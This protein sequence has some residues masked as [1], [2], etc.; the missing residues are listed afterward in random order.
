M[1]TPNDPNLPIPS[2]DSLLTE[3]LADRAESSVTSVAPPPSHIGPWRLIEPLG[4]GGMGTVYLAGR[5][6]QELVWQAAIKIIRAGVGGGAVI[7]RFRAERQILASLDH[8]NIA[9]MYDAGTL[10]DGR[11]YLVL[12][13][14]R[15]V[16]IDRYCR[17]HGLSMDRRVEIFQK[18]CSAVRHAHQHLVIHRDLK[19]SNILVGSDGEPKLL[20]FGIAKLLDPD[21]FPLPIDDTQTGVRPMTPRYA[22]PEQIRGLPVGTSSDVFSLGVLLYELITGSL[23]FSYSS[24]SAV[25][26]DRVLSS[27]RPKRPSTA[28]VAE[29]T[30]LADRELRRGRRLLR[31]DLDNIVL[32]ALREEPS[33]R[34]SSVEALQQDLDHLSAGRPV[35][36]TRDT[37]PYVAGKFL[38]RHRL[39]IGALAILLTTLIGATWLVSEQAKK[40]ALERD[41][42]RTENA[43]AHRMLDFLIDTFDVVDQNS[44]LGS[45]VTAKEI[46]D[47]AI[48]RIDQ[49]L[50][51]DADAQVRLFRATGSIYK[52]LGLVSEARESLEKSLRL[53]ESHLGPDHL[54]T[55]ES[56]LVLGDLFESMTLNAEAAE[57]QKEALRRSN[58][59]LRRDHPL[60]ARALLE[61]AGALAAEGKLEE[62]EQRVREA[63]GIFETQPV[64]DV[65]P[66][67]DCRQLLSRIRQAHGDLE[68][69]EAMLRA[70]LDDARAGLGEKSY[71]VAI[72]HQDLGDF[73]FNQGRVDEA[74]PYYL[75]SY[76]IG[77]VAHSRSPT[78]VPVTLRRLGALA[79]HR[80][81]F[82]SALELY[83]RSIE[84]SEK[85]VAGNSENVLFNMGL[86]IT[87]LRAAELCK[88]SGDPDEAQEH[89]RRALEPSLKTLVTGTQ[90]AAYHHARVLIGL[91]RNKE[92]RTVLLELREVLSNPSA[93]DPMLQQLDEALGTN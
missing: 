75:R 43:R 38:R 7:R 46:L 44:N 50:E 68:G 57:K 73:L 55:L 45:S 29:L 58:D 92:A 9:S 62:A 77:S 49:D 79:D 53:A 41:R 20:D 6:D 10:P 67:I 42:A 32:K 24:T 11:P 87:R 89:Y 82:E 23:P 17:N 66:M 91:G 93:L 22:S 65:V 13:Y 12:E 27:T 33:K 51:Q 34:Y 80:D 4:V 5:D 64:R 88:R 81:D 36:A 30:G 70:S 78:F 84:E 2:S 14:V 69:A 40:A 16:P 3:T 31:G 48:L 52:R 61:V 56:M 90:T 21:T 47:E 72:A 15:G 85:L 35:S 25:E 60:R 86:V 1:S 74:E 18:V 19:P 59:S 39:G 71:W 26:M 83:H 76:E 37:L 63:L 8:P 54:Q 28:I